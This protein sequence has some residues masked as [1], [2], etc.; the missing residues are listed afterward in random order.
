VVHVALFQHV[1]AEVVE[2]D[3]LG[4]VGARGVLVK[5]VGE[6]S[7]DVEHGLRGEFEGCFGW[8]RRHSACRI[9][10]MG[11]FVSKRDLTSGAQDSP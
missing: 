10:E 11:C 2:A 9:S 6:R 1:G 8:R 3:L 4:A 7:T 5:E